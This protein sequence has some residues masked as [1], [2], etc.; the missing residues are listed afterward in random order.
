MG[1]QFVSKKGPSQQVYVLKLAE[2]VKKNHEL[3]IYLARIFT[4]YRKKEIHDFKQFHSFVKMIVQ[5]PRLSLSKQER[6]QL[7]ELIHLIYQH[8]NFQMIRAEF[9]EEMTAYFGPF[10]TADPSPQVYREPSIYENHVL[11]GETGHKCDVVFFEKVDRPMELIECKST[12]AT[13]MTLT[14]DFETTRKSTKGKITYLNKVREYLMV[15]YVEP[16]LFFSCYDTNIDVIKENI[17]SN[18][19]FTHYLFLNPIQLCKKK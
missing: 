10:Q 2:L 6:H 7:M 11:I 18:W 5:H 8:S 3:F 1:L 19:G 15:H 14:K 17:Y 16:V 4:T 12:L 13:F 9:L